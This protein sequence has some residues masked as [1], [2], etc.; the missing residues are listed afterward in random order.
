MNE[1]ILIAIGYISKMLV[2]RIKYEYLIKPN[3]IITHH[4][5]TVPK[6]IEKIFE[7]LKKKEWDETK[8]TSKGI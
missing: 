1:L 8:T 2:D 6:E 4:T 5:I 7:E 3:I